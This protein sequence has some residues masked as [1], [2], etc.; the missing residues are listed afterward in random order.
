MD[1]LDGCKYKIYNM[2]TL[3]S[4]RIIKTIWNFYIFVCIS[5]FFFHQLVFFQILIKWSIK[6][7]V[8][9]KQS[10]AKYDD[11]CKKILKT[12]KQTVCSSTCTILKY[13]DLVI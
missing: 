9:R 10:S 12:E 11:H 8:E 6:W 2:T 5:S 7:H 3:Q 13:W 4:A 1:L